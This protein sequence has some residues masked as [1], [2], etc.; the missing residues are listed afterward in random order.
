MTITCSI[1]SLPPELIDLILS[2][3][4]KANQKDGVRFTYGLNSELTSSSEATS[5]VNRYV[6]GPIPEASAR[7]DASRSIRQVCSSWGTWATRY[8]FYQLRENC[9]HERERWADLPTSRSR[10]SL[11]EMINDPRGVCVSRDPY[12][13]L[14]RTAAFLETFP[15]VADCVRQLRFDGFTT[16]ETDRRILSTITSCQHLEALTIPHTVLQRCMTGAWMDLLG[17]KDGTRRPLLSLEINGARVPNGLGSSEKNAT[18][19]SLEDPRVTF[20][21]L[22]RLK[23]SGHSS[24]SLIKDLDLLTIAESATNLQSLQLTSIP[25]VSTSTALALAQASR[26]TIRLLQ[27]RHLCGH[28][29]L[30]SSVLS[31]SHTC[32]QISTLAELRDLDMS[33]PLICHSLFTTNR[34]QW[35]GMCFIRFEGFCSRLH[36]DTK[37]DRATSLRKVL[38][39][40]R[41]LMAERLRCAI[42]LN[43]ELSWGAYVFDARNGTVSRTFLHTE[44]GTSF[45][46]L[47]RVEEIF[48]LGRS[49]FGSDDK[50][51]QF[52]VAEDDFLEAMQDKDM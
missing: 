11:Y 47:Q 28:T 17:V 38:T 13:S 34:A 43:I 33:L 52:T 48:R 2:L 27:H 19:I 31:Q 51:S 1:E 26:Q 32:K 35:A 49:K 22:T 36:Q 16:I 3:A 15:H 20:G 12:R 23:I 21:N 50:L 46:G 8:N 14:T 24:Q 6:R 5:S 37:F 25:S 44:K 30:E 42:A 4:A 18:R 9:L 7:W 40:A 39:A 10:Y 45:H 41:C 29:A